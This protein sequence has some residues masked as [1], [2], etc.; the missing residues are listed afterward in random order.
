MKR[1][2]FFSLLLVLCGTVLFA[3]PSPSNVL[4]RRMSGGSSGPHFAVAT[5]PLGLIIKALPAVAYIRTGVIIHQLRYCHFFSHNTGAFYSGFPVRGAFSKLM[6]FSVDHGYEADYFMKFLIG[7]DKM[8]NEDMIAGMYFGIGYQISKYQLN[9]AQYWVYDNA[10]VG[11][12]YFFDSA[13]VF[14]SKSIQGAW[15]FL[16]MMDKGFFVDMDLTI[17]GRTR[18]LDF[19]VNSPVSGEEVTTQNATFKDEHLIVP[20]AFLPGHYYKYIMGHFRFGISF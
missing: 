3:T 6:S 17:G 14:S 18:E 13:P 10:S 8:S 2:L 7:K 16:V 12:E 19:N 11:Q 1:V 15:G 9:T 5:N 4:Q 20:D